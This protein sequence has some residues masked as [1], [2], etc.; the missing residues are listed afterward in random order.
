MGNWLPRK[1]EPTNEDIA[2]AHLTA[3][4]GIEE[5]KGRTKQ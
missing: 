5:F 4:E 1:Q 3:V 2:Q